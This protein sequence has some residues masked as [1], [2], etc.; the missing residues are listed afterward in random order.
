MPRFTMKFTDRDKVEVSYVR[1]GGVASVILGTLTITPQQMDDLMDLMH[2][3]ERRSSV[4][5]EMEN[6]NL[7]FYLETGLPQ[8]GKAGPLSPR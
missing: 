4:E 6:L 2:K 1:D 8:G 5:V 7:P 3:G